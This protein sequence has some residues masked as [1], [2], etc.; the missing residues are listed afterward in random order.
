MNTT[1]LTQ[2]ETS[3][4]SALLQRAIANKQLNLTVKSPYE[5]LDDHKKDGWNDRHDGNSTSSDKWVI[6]EANEYVGNG[7]DVP[8]VDMYVDLPD[9]LFLCGKRPTPP[10][11]RRILNEVEYTS[12]LREVNRLTRLLHDY[13]IKRDIYCRD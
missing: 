13:E 12:T 8:T 5:R 3:R 2:K 10:T 6:E 1:P 11:S 7:I 9:L 4:L